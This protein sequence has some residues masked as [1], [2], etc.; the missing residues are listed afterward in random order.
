MFSETLLELASLKEYGPYLKPDLVIWQITE[1]NDYLDL[2]LEKNNPIL[3][4]YLQNNFNQ[5]LIEKQAIIDKSLMSYIRK[6]E[7]LFTRDWATRLIGI[8]SSLLNLKKV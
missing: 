8:E 2:L 7:V 6:S 3:M 4:K 5:G 1:A